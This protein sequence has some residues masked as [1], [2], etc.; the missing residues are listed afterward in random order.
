MRVNIG[1]LRLRRKNRRCGISLLELLI[2]LSAFGITMAA[3]SITQVSTITLSRSNQDE[4]VATD[5][6]LSTLETMRDEDNFREIFARWNG[7]TD[8]DPDLATGP[9]P[10]NAFDVPGLEPVRNDP[11]G[12]VGEIVFPGDGVQ[13]LEN[14]FDRKLGMPRDLDLGSVDGE[15]DA[16]DHKDDYRIL[17][18][19]VRV[20]WQGP[21]GV[22]LVEVVGTFAQ[23]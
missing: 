17:P 3:L 15:F 2:A 9:S 13:L 22:Q 19:L 5:A 8:D 14:G 23:R 1:L 4:S 21:R 6:A 11:D 18:V 12:R 7:T 20:R 10:G 16:L